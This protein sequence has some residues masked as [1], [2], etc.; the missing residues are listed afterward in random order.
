MLSDLLDF[1]IFLCIAISYFIP[2]GYFL[3]F[4]QFLVSDLILVI[5]KLASV[6][7]GIPSIMFL[8]TNSTPGNIPTLEKYS[9]LWIFFEFGVPEIIL[10]CLLAEIF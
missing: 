8:V 5:I 10:F 1:S 6:M 7:K 9:C 2:V 3:F 4:S